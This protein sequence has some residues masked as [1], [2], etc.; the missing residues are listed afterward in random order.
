MYFRKFSY[1]SARRDH[2]VISSSRLH[3]QSMNRCRNCYLGCDREICHVCTVRRLCQHCHRR[4]DSNCFDNENEDTC[5]VRLFVL[6]FVSHHIERIIVKTCLHC[7]DT[8]TD[9]PR[10]GIIVS[11]VVSRYIAS[12]RTHPQCGKPNNRGW[13]LFERSMYFVKAHIK[14]WDFG[15]PISNRTTV[16]T[17]YCLCYRHVRNGETD[18]KYT[19]A[20]LH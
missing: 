2:S 5:S 4:L 3:R 14:V 6:P 15:I 1:K 16:F 13:L 19:T 18:A 8:Q 9:T 11:H 10:Y 20:A 17:F 12:Q 7:E